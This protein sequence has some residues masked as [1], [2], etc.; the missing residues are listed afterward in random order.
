[1][2]KRASIESLDIELLMRILPQ[3]AAH[4]S[5]L[6]WSLFQEMDK[7]NRRNHKMVN[8]F[9]RVQIKLKEFWKIS[10]FLTQ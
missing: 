1:M 3:M 10:R 7:Y 6:E 5:V 2:N 9:E 4:I 8:K